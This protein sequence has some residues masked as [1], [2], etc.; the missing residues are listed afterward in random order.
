MKGNIRKGQIIKKT[1]RYFLKIY[2]IN[3]V[4]SYNGE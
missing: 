2:N 4:K 3:T 1:H